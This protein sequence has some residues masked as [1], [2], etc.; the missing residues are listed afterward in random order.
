MNATGSTSN[1]TN[2]LLSLGMATDSGLS[3]PGGDTEGTGFSSLLSR[4]M[5]VN[6]Q[7]PLAL[8]PPTAVAAQT[9]PPEQQRLPLAMPPLLPEDAADVKDL[10]GQIHI[11]LEMA[12]QTTDMAPSSPGL[13]ENVTALAVVPGDETD[14]A[15]I[16][17]DSDSEASPVL[18]WLAVPIQPEPIKA[19]AA[20][21]PVDDMSTQGTVTP[22]VI[23]TAPGKPDRAKNSGAESLVSHADRTPDDAPVTVEVTDFLLPVEENTLTPKGINQ[24]GPQMM[25]PANAAGANAATASSAQPPVTATPVDASSEAGQWITDS[26]GEP[27]TETERQAQNLQ[28][29]KD[30]LEFGQDRREWGSALGAR[31]MTMVADDVQKA[32]IQL[33][34][35]ELGSLEIK[36][37]VSQDQA[38]VQVQAQH[39]HVRDVLE[40]N[41]QRLRDALAAQ[42][43]TLAGFDVSERG[44]GGSGSGQP[45]DGQGASTA[46]GDLLAE[47][48]PTEDKPQ[49]QMSRHNLLDTFA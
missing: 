47:D 9:L 21:R 1:A 42:G 26:H 28:L 46:G 32:R 45:G 27:L 39:A 23:H 3:G 10:L 14:T 11:G 33:D 35:P 5:P 41:A 8:L 36:L 2:I 15:E 22:A 30:K 4:L 20:V 34:P 16:P 38:T 29:S 12:A 19:P 13:T 6:E 24:Q 18:P 31:I 25:M 40:A 44:Q 48:S 7:G 37:H 49:P 17:D 43:M